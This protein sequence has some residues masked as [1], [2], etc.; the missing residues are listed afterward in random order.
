PSPAVA[1]SLFAVASRGETGVLSV[2]AGATGS[3]AGG[4]AAGGPSLH[5]VELERG[6]VHAMANVE[7]RL[8]GEEALGRLLDR[9]GGGAVATF[10]AR[11][12]GSPL[13]GFR[14]T[15]FHPARPLRVH[16]ERSSSGGDLRTPPGDLDGTRLRLM[17]TPHASCL[18]P[19]E[20]RVVA[21]LASPRRLDELVPLL[22][23]PRLDRLLRFLQAAGALLVDDPQLP[24]AYAA[25]GL[26]EG[27][28]A[29][30]VKRA[31]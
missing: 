15:P 31:W 1:R 10:S 13:I 2:E 24:A 18:D 5:R 12:P 29:D 27:A 23:R 3:A 6:W 30:E 21:L 7:R 25:L 4:N 22:G 19:D 26:V 17:I 8:S 9:L 28:P 16:F 11:P 14:F 20:Q